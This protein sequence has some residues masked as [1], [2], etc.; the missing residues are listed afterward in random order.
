MM[1]SVIVLLILVLLLEISISAC[2]GSS[3]PQ[4]LEV[5]RTPID[6]PPIVNVN[7]TCMIQDK[8]GL[9]NVSLMFSVNSGTYNVDKMRI[10][11][12]DFYNGTFYEQIP[13]QSTD[14]IV[15]YYV[16]AVDSIG[17]VAQSSSFSYEV[18]YDKAGPMISDVSVVSPLG[19][20]VLPTEEVNVKAIVA[21]LGSGVKNAT[22]FYG[23]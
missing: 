11:D 5:T 6:P 14:T 3:Y 20:P 17:Y 13:G 16:V 10:I 9:V 15:K 18:S 4:I 21:D 12:G 1:K 23:A 22:L 19:S 8:Y 7:V 2:R